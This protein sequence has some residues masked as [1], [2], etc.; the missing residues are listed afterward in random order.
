[1]SKLLSFEMESRVER[2]FPFFYSIFLSFYLYG[3]L[4]FMG[5]SIDRDEGLLII[6]VTLCVFGGECSISATTFFF[7]LDVLFFLVI[8]G[9]DSIS[10]VSTYWISLSIL[11]L[12]F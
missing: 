7:D 10:L 4:S 11:N 9:N 5:L 2:P 8:G 6:L 1:M 12:Y 3:L